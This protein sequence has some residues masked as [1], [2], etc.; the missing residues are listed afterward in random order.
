[1]GE[2]RTVTTLKRKR[3]EIAASIRMYEKKIAQARA[4]M[5]HVAAAIRIFEASDRPRDLARYVDHHRLFKR[6]EPW[7]ICAGAW[8]D[9]PRDTKELAVA[10]MAAKGLGRD[11]CRSS[12]GHR[13]PPHSFAAHAG[14]ARARETGRETQR[15]DGLAVAGSLASPHRTTPH[16]APLYPPH[17]VVNKKFR[18]TIDH[19]T[20]QGQLSAA[21]F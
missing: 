2:I 15:R 19:R 6:G 20:N 14:R 3:E 18:T 7:A 10:M 11:R 1:M 5:A 21:R 4:D 17:L 13:A 16:V 12:Q 8:K 9:G